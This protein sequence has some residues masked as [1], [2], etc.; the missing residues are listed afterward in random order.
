MSIDMELWF[1][2]G[3]GS[4]PFF[5]SEINSLES[6]SW[7]FEPKPEKDIPNHCLMTAVNF[8]KTR[9]IITYLEHQWEFEA[10]ILQFWST[11]QYYKTVEYQLHR[12]TG[13]GDILCL[14]FLTR[15][16]CL[17]WPSVCKVYDRTVDTGLKIECDLSPSPVLR[18]SW[19]STVL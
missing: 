9:Q 17:W 4:I 3:F 18:W 15:C 1:K 11:N 12:S 16:R 19:Y 5:S 14:P 6:R 7:G 13:G 2:N 10:H 8:E